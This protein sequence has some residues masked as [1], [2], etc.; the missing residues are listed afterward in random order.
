MRPPLNAEERKRREDWVKRTLGGI[1]AS[2]DWPRAVIAL[3]EDMVDSERPLLLA[4]PSSCNQEDRLYN[5][6][7]SAAL[8][9]LLAVLERFQRAAHAVPGPVAQQE[10]H[11]TAPNST[12]R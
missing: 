8:H 3:I 2:D 10:Q 4:P 6:G 7:R 11:R 9:D 5:A 12:Q 1:P